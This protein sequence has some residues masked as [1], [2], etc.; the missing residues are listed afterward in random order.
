MI[1]QRKGKLL[2]N[3]S[4]LLILQFASYAVPLITAPYLTRVLGIDLFGMVFFAIAL[5]Q[6]CCIITDYGF[7]LSATREIAENASSVKS[8]NEINGAVFACKSLLLIPA[9]FICLAP[10]FFIERYEEQILLFALFSISIVGQTFQPVWHFQGIERMQ[11]I[12]IS[13]LL[14]RFSYLGFVLILVKTKQDY[15]L[16]GAAAAA[17]QAIAAMVSLSYMR[18]L[19]Y[20]SAKPNWRL[21]KSSFSKSTEY[22]WSRVASAAYTTGGTLILGVT[23]TPASTAIYSAAE[24]LYRGA[25]SVIQPIAQALYPY[26][27]RTK[28]VNTYK[29]VL[30]GVVAAAA[31]GATIGITASN[32]VTLLIFG[33]EFEESASIL[34][35]LMVAFVFCAPSI[36]LGYPLLGAMGH[37]SD[38]NKSIFLGAT[39]QLAGLSV[40]A[41]TSKIN[42]AGVATSIVVAEFFTFVFRARKV[43]AYKILSREN[44]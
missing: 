16:I 42:P 26:M 41:L 9:I 24:Q 32:Q 34:S 28:D 25:Q 22:F 2:S 21:V 23:S 27:A 31:I 29:K 37:G 35:I 4:A 38:V 30:V 18:H 44:S 3:A 6:A 36:F 17:S 43:H 10:V 20:R 39:L 19:G 15:W 14:A 12:T 7:N 5:T 8:V 33:K 40:L 11:A 1:V 13:I